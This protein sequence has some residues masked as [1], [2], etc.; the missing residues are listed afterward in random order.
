MLFCR[1]TVGEH[2]WFY[3]QL[4]GGGEGEEER[5]AMLEDLGIPEKRDQESQVLS[6]GMQVGTA[7]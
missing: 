7:N 1:L 5:D 3:S 2:L 4:K 6:G